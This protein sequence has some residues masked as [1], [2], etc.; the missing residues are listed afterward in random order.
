[1]VEALKAAARAGE[2]DFSA[3]VF[4]VKGV[5]DVKAFVSEMSSLLAH[6][7]VEAYHAGVK[8]G[9]KTVGSEFYTS[10]EFTVTAS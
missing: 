3:T 1:M 8:T 6:E 9:A 10:V 4:C 5:P 7:G 2:K